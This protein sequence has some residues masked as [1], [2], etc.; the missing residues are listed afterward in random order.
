MLYNAHM[1]LV[2]YVDY[3]NMSIWPPDPDKSALT[4]LLKEPSVDHKK[5]ENWNK[6]GYKSG[7][8]G[9]KNSIK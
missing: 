7:T 8:P 3:K 6:V 2:D 9:M 5:E 4:L 1:N